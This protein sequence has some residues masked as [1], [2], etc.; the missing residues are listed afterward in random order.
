MLDEILDALDQDFTVENRHSSKTFCS[1]TQ[2][3]RNV[4]VQKDGVAPYDLFL[5]NSFSK[6]KTHSVVEFIF[7]W[8]QRYW[9]LFSVSLS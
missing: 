5:H 7:I 8:K 6:F 2:A 4:P 9:A 1:V 3:D